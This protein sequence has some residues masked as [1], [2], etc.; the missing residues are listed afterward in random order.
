MVASAGYFRCFDNKE[1]FGKGLG[2]ACEINVIRNKWLYGTGYKPDRV[3]VIYF[4]KT[5]IK[6][7]PDALSHIHRFWVVDAEELK[8]LVAWLKGDSFASSAVTAT[9]TD[10]IS[11]PPPILGYLPRLADRQN[12]F[13]FFVS[14]IA[15][16]TRE[17]VLFLEGPSGHGKTK[18]VA[19][20]LTYAQQ[21]LSTEACVAVDFK[22]SPTREVAWQ[23]LSLGLASTFS[24]DD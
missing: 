1:D 4:D 3:R 5:N 7:I 15:G 14:M 23:T 19:E 22:S 9:A 18:L 10:T 11:W 16:G 8:S 21:A 17:R 24:A 20:C 12:E 6:N 2:A 13:A